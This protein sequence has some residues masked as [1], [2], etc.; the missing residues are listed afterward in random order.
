MLILLSVCN[1]RA[2]KLEILKDQRYQ[3]I[4]S[5]IETKRITGLEEVFNI[6][7]L[8]VVRADMQMNYGTLR[9]RVLAS[10]TLTL[11]DFRLLA[12]LFEVDPAEVFALALTDAKR[13]LKRSAVKKNLKK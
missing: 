13:K 4:K 7:P 1:F 11:K 8:S 3:A 9:K 5:L 12:E 6:I 2:D 10:D